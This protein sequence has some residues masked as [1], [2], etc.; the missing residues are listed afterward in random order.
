MAAIPSVS[1]YKNGD[2]SKVD[3]I[4]TRYSKQIPIVDH[5]KIPGYNISSKCLGGRSRWTRMARRGD[6]NFVYT[7]PYSK[8]QTKFRG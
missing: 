5:W 1:F 3:V 7:Y 6:S 2:E 4:R 8:R